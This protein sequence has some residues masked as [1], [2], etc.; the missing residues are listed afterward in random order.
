[1]AIVDLTRLT[2]FAAPTRAL[3]LAYPALLA[4]LVYP[5]SAFAG[6]AV[7]F[8][9]DHRIDGPAAPFYLAIDKG[10]FKAEGLDVT[11][12]AASGPAESLKRLN[13]GGYDMGV[14]DINGLI[15][16]RDGNA[17]S[18]K[19]VFIVFDKPCYA[20]IA[21]KSR[22]IAA[23]KDLE[24]K[25]LGAPVG[26]ESTA[27]WP[28]FAKVNGINAGKVT[29][30]NV[31]LPVREPML[32]A[33]ELDAV[34]GCSFKSYIDLKVDGVPAD[35]LALLPFADHG[36]VLYGDAI[37]AASSFAADKPE[38]VQGFLRAYLKALKDAVRDPAQAVEAMLR[39][40]EDL[41]QDV[42]T[43]R[44]RLA[45]RDDILTPA[46]KARGYGG[47]DAER[48]AEAIDQ[49]ALAYRFKAKD[50]AAEVFDP[51]FLPA[52]AERKVS[53]TAAR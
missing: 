16:Y 4:A 21:R 42:E 5:A 1:M 17:A 52:A 20:I 33:G 27:A 26:A 34:S 7:H 6:T 8:T 47:V 19:A 12:D 9:L 50:K 46:V 10:Y 22:G 44:L 14:A 28:I 43:E 37:V 36:V 32:A 45:I 13:A 48:F 38:A 39:R 41:K 29:I 24:G 31:G 40:G 2:R 49:I 25:R 15:K 18:I 53:E 35:D 51:A 30:E 11:I 3:A 23:P